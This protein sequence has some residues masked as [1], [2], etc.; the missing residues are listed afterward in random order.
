MHRGFQNMLLILI[1]IAWFALAALVVVLCRMAGRS[2]AMLAQASEQTQRGS[3]PTVTLTPR[4]RWHETP[5]VAGSRA[6]LAWA[7]RGRATRTRQGRCI[8][9]S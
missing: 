3:L 4:A 7:P 2:D 1:P 6:A 8:A 9:G 5:Y